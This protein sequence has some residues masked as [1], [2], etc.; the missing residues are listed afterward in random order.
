VLRE[1]SIPD[2]FQRPEI[3]ISTTPERE[4]FLADRMRKLDAGQRNGRCPEELEA[5]DRGTPSLD[6]SMILLDQIVEVL[7]APDLN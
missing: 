6:R 7:A 5:S 2:F 4:S 1:H 3:P